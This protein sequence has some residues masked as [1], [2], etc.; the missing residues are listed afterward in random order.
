MWDKLYPS[1]FLSFIEV[2]RSIRKAP[3]FYAD[4]LESL[5]QTNYQDFIFKFTNNVKFSTADITNWYSS[6]VSPTENFFNVF[7]TFNQN[8]NYRT[9]RWVSLNALD[10][11]FTSMF[12]SI[13][14]QQ[15]VLAN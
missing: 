3:W 7:G 8:N 1:L 13:S 9:L 6:H 11:K 12:F 14:T 2:A 5:V 10:Q 15:R 4:S